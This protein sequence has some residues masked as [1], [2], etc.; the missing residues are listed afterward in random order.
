MRKYIDGIEHEIDIVKNGI[1][2]TDSDTGEVT[3]VGGLSKMAQ[4]LFSPK[5]GVD[6]KAINFH[7]GQSINTLDDIA[8]VTTD[9]DAQDKL[10]DIYRQSYLEQFNVSNAAASLE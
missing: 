3:R 8:A 5:L 2:R 4:Q 9:Q 7:A 10:A 6:D 1:E